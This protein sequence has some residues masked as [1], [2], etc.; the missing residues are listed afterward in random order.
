[1]KKIDTTNSKH[2]E[3]LKSDNFS[4]LKDPAMAILKIFSSVSF[5]TPYSHVKEY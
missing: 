4:T 5:V 1:M 2:L 3:Y